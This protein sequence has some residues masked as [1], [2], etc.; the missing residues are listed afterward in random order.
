MQP[1][2]RA[3]DVPQSEEQ[4]VPLCYADEGHLELSPALIPCI[5]APDAVG[6]VLHLARGGR[7]SESEPQDGLCE[8]I[9][10]NEVGSGYVGGPLL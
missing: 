2:N 8:V 4:P 5:H 6:P 10:G 1:V 3:L 7:G 9:A